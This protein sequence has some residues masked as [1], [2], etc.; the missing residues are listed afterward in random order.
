MLKKYTSVPHAIYDFFLKLTFTNLLS[1]FNQDFE[2]LLNAK[3]Q[4]RKINKY[5]LL[6]FIDT[7]TSER[8]GLKFS[9]GYIEYELFLQGSSREDEYKTRYVYVYRAWNRSQN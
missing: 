7:Q 8:D 2:H 5:M 3:K 6:P 9:F 4:A 1:S